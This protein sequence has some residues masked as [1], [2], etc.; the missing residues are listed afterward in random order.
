MT[1]YNSA[2]GTRLRKLEVADCGGNQ[3]IYP[4]RIIARDEADKERQFA[5]LVAAGKMAPDTLAICRMIVPGG[6]T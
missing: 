1:G 3:K 4:G 6:A 2:L 5:E